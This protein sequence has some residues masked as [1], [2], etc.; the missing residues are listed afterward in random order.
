[1]APKEDFHFETVR[2]LAEHLGYPSADLDVVPAPAID[3]FAGV[4]YFLDL[5][6]VGPGARVLDLGSGSGMDSF[7]AANASGSQICTTISV[8]SAV[9]RPFDRWQLEVEL[10]AQVLRSHEHQSR[11]ASFSARSSTD[12]KRAVGGAK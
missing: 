5:A 3:S 2:G 10:N 4:G 7:L 9:R 8:A 12:V 6:E 1:M 11:S